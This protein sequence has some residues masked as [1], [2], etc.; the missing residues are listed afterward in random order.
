M[1]DTGPISEGTTM[2]RSHHRRNDLPAAARR[3][4]GFT[5]PLVALSLMAVLL[6]ATVALDGSQ[7]YPQRRSAQNAADA[8][9][10]SGAQ[11]LD[12]AK[13]FGGSAGAVYAEALSVAKDNG[14]HRI[15]CT[16]INGIGTPVTGTDGSMACLAATT[17]VPS[18][19][20]GVRIRTYVDRNTT[21]GAI[22]GRSK[23]TATATAAATVQKLN[24]T[25]SPFIVCANASP[26]LKGNGANKPVGFDVLKTNPAVITDWSIYQRP[27][28]Q[29]FVFNTDGTVDLDPG[30]V[31]AVNALN[32][33][34]GVPL[35]GSENAIPACG[36]GGGAFDGNGSYETV[37]LPAWVRY[38]TGGG[39]SASAAEQ[40]VSASPCPDP[41]PAGYDAS[42]NPCDVML[43]LAIDGDPA[44]NQL[45][46]VSMA[47]FRITGT[48][49]GNPKYYGRIRSD[50]RF[51]TGGITS[52]D[53]VTASSV[54]VVRLIE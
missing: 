38:T 44:T 22:T 14:A 1:S 25:G 46:V 43:P 40:V 52:I 50:I 30:K 42:A 9:A 27:F 8:A 4:R 48:G 11:A 51:A 28:T 13:F 32:G 3:E 54:R 37:T 26:L 39:Y 41:L 20:Q 5:I 19:A 18:A 21:F 23:L 29:P 33:G 15:D 34:R 10:V 6:L 17:A 49:N 35:V 47:V 24:S 12:Q 16:F 36:A 2:L 31:A 7:A 45:R 53:P